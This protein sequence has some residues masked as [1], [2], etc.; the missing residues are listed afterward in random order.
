M[1]DDVQ[2]QGHINHLRK[3]QDPTAGFRHGKGSI[4]VIRSSVPKPFFLATSCQ[5]LLLGRVRQAQIVGG[6]R[7]EARL[8]D[9]MVRIRIITAQDRTQLSRYRG[10]ICDQ[11]NSRASVT[12]PSVNIETAQL[13]ARSMPRPPDDEWR[14]SR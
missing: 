14:L 6:E 8:L 13:S 12:F 3:A 10:L 2:L 1:G 9:D 7:V 5:A 4:S 11:S